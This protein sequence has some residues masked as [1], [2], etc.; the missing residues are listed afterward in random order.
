MPPSP[1]R[2]VDEALHCRWH[3]TGLRRREKTLGVFGTEDP[4]IPNVGV[5]GLT[6]DAAV[7]NCVDRCR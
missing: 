4:A 2:R 6:P 7:A 1:R 5:N 3:D